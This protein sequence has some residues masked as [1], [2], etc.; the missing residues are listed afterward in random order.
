[1]RRVIVLLATLAA[2]GAP[3]A[4]RAGAGEGAC[5]LCIDCPTGPTDCTV[6][7]GDDCDVICLTERGCGDWSF[8]PL[9]ACNAN[10]PC[11]GMQPESAKAPAATTLG[12]AAVAAALAGFGARRLMRRRA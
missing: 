6:P 1:M 12:L 8:A 3:L 4:E 7:V 2:L 5:C 10:P 9:E 11:E